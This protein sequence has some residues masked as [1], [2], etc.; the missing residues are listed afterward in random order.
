[1]GMRAQTAGRILVLLAAACGAACVSEEVRAP[2]ST[3]TFDD[4]RLAG[5]S[6]RQAPPPQ[7]EQSFPFDLLA[8][9]TAA[10][11]SDDRAFAADTSPF[12]RLGNDVIRGIDGSYTKLYRVRAGRS[13][14]IVRLLQVYVPGFPLAEN[15]PH[16]PSAG[17]TEVI[18][19][20][21][22]TNFY[23]DENRGKIGA[24]E[25]VDGQVIADVLHITAPAEVLLYIDELLNKIMADLPQVE[26]EVRVVEVNLDDT[27]DWDS[28]VLARRLDDRDLPF[29]ATTNPPQGNFGAGIPIIDGGVA[30]GIGAGFS[31]LASSAANLSGFL[32]SLQGVHSSLVV[33]GVISLLQTVGTAEIISSPTIT[34]LNGHRAKLITGDQLP[35][36]KAGGTLTSPQVTTEFKP[37]G[38]T[39]DIVPFI[40]NDDLI[41]IDLSIDVSSQTG[42]VPFNIGGTEV[43]SPIISQRT[44]ATTVHVY[45]GQVFALGGLRA[46]TEIESITKVP[47]L[48]D[49]PILGWLFKSRLS[50]RR[51]TE[52]LFFITPRILIPS[53]TLLNPLEAWE[54]GGSRR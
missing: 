28:K 31:S 20:V 38:V 13:A 19:Y 51:N 35:I 23:Q 26:L 33:D 11:R 14:D 27:I 53:E 12:H 37:T 52:I 18:R 7:D 32:V 21:S 16:D 40:V 34:V 30:S 47:I 1:M 36:F 42:A 43:S 4:D 22:Q 41:R 49:I 54:R 25:A 10:D 2:G 6:Q 9:A 46:S 45:A 15:T 44:A 24:R 3:W 29:D 48:G 50:Q 39:M 5:M 17:P 8:P